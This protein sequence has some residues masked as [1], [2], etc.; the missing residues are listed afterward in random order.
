MEEIKRDI[1]ASEPKLKEMP[2]TVPDGYFET[3]EAQALQHKESR[4]DRRM[5]P[6][7][8]AAAVLAFLFTAGAL[9]LQNS[10]HPEELTQE[11]FLVFSTQMTN[12]EYYDDID[13]I[14]DAGI[15]DE[16]IIEYLIYTGI[17]AEEIELS[18]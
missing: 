2:Y 12:V 7:A 13:Q 10:P 4:S 14:A 3:F 15:A 11:D 8:V 1:L 6:Y 18:K 9:L 17:S 5:I 16:D